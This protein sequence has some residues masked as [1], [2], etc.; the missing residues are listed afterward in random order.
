VILGSELYAVIA[1]RVT[2]GGVRDGDL[3]E[4]AFGE[5]AQADVAA[6]LGP[7]VVL[8]GEYGADQADQ[9]GPVWEDPDDVGAAADLAVQSFL[10]GSAWGAVLWVTAY[11]RAA[12]PSGSGA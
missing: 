11:G 3:G 12:Y 7:F 4:A 9:G 10:A 6:H 5:D 2:S 1:V 8:L